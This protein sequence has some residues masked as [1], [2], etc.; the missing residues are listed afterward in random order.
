MN[1]NLYNKLSSVAGKRLHEIYQQGDILVDILRDYAGRIPP[2]KKN[3]IDQLI[4]EY[5][6]I[7]KK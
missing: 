6:K 5:E 7:K 2:P 3:E 1:V 4:D